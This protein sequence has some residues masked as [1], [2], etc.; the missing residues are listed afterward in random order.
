MW[1]L[2]ISEIKELIEDP[3]NM[4]SWKPVDT[5]GDVPGNISHHKAAVFGHQVVIFGGINDYENNPHT[6]EFDTS[7]NKW[8]KLTQNGEVPEPRDDH[9][10]S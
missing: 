4:I 3:E 10:L 5:T 9:S 7:R 8:T 1:K 6:Y 2:S